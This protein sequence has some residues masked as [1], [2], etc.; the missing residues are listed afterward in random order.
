MTRI[1]FVNRYFY[2]DVSATSQM[3][4]DLA[5]RLACAGLEVHV[6]CSRQCYDDA[7][8]RLPPTETVDGVSIHRAATTR[9]GRSW[10]PGR[11]FDYLTF[12][13]SASVALLHLLRPHDVLV[14]KT[15]PPLF[16]LPA[17]L[18]AALKGARL[19][20]WL[21]DLFPEVAQRLGAR[22]L[23]GFAGDVL[24]RLRD[25]TL[26]A[27]DCNVV[28]G[29]G[30]QR[31]LESRGIP[32]RKLCMI[33]NWFDAA[34]AA[35]GTDQREQTIR[36]PELEG[37]FVVCHSGNLG[38]A[39]DITTLLEAALHLRDQPDIVFLIVG[40]GAGYDELRRRA[41]ERGLASAFRFEPYLPREEL[42][43]GLAAAAVHL[44]TLLPR[45]EGLVVPSKIYG[46]FAAG[47]PMIFV[48]DEQG[49]VARKLARTG[50]GVSVPVGAGRRLARTILH[51]R[52]DAVLSTA[53]GERARSLAAQH[54]ADEGASRWLTLITDRTSSAAAP[55]VVAGGL[56]TSA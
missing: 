6:V 30:M 5:F 36:W 26:H 25:R 52:S 24:L 43:D 38:R 44:V 39:H 55:R 40:G 46:V 47:R 20:N 51:L 11:A 14:I 15:D 7:S 27:A 18:I 31:H 19:V 50:A 35:P 3:L 54:T 22:W 28:I 10:L 9:F 56:R 4:G 21:Q 29:H 45:L 33:E 41:E 23:E 16:S 2:P 42:N 1:V 37:K 34:S 13:L 48:G 17:A 49:E 12:Y 32:A 8:R 53:M